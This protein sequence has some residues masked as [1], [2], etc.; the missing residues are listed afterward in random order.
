MHRIR[1]SLPYFKEYDY[2]VEVVTVYQK[3]YQSTQDPL[4]LQS[5]PIGIKIHQVKAFSKKWTTKI[6]LGSLAL[7]SLYFYKAYVNKL[8]KQTKF[9]LIYF[10]TTEFPLCILGAYW[11]KKFGIPYV[12][13]MQDPWYSDYYESKPKAERPKK[14][15]LSYRM[16]KFLEPIAMKGVSGIISV[17]ENYITNLRARYPHLNSIPNEV[18][19]FGASEVDFEIAKQNTDQLKL[20]YKLEQDLI[21]LVYVGRGG[22]DMDK[23]LKILFSTFKKGLDANE[24]LFKKLRF[25]FI[26]TSYAPSGEGNETIA[27]IAKALGVDSYVTEI[28]NRIGFYESIK[29]LES[30]DGLII[31]GSNEAAYTASKLSPYVLAKRPLLAIFNAKS[32]I[33]KTI[34]TCAA[35][36]LMLHDEDPNLSYN[37]FKEYLIKV[38]SNLSPN[39]NWEAFEP[40]TAPYLTQRQTDFF[41]KI[42]S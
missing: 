20:F 1:M 5:V 31:I 7:R 21:N 3:Y 9:D 26:G 36:D 11:K 38:E 4:L 27:P 28:T 17:S 10:S 19:T 15:W 18:I 33:V 32:S 39:T 29:N 16:H 34:R 24:N 2:E 13:D 35:G 37:I 12:I 40:Y 30:A 22:Y 6:G 8:L 42:I 23:S 14:Y 41:D 25:Y